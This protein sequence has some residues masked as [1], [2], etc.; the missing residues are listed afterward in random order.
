MQMFLIM[1]HMQTLMVMDTFLDSMT[2]EQHLVLIHTTQTL[3]DA[4][5]LMFQTLLIGCK[6]TNERLSELTQSLFVFMIYLCDF[7]FSSFIR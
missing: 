7:L 2:V 3:R 4:A 6:N 1:R 5:I